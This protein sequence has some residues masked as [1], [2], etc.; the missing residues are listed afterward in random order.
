M[1]LFTSELY[2]RGQSQDDA[3]RDEVDRL[4]ED[5]N[6]QYEQ[7]L[8]QIRPQLPTHIQS[9]LDELLLHDADVW[10]LARHGDQ[11]IMVLRKD[12]PPRDVVILTYT[13]V[14]EP[15]INTAAIPPEHCSRVMQFLYDEFDLVEDDGKK[16]YVQSILFSNGWEVQIKFRDVKVERADAIFPVAG[17]SL[18][19]VSNVFPQ[20][21]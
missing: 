12:I 17:T 16:L 7:R 4:W 9:F 10:S 20:S 18:V 8:Q 2:V 5:A 19:P 11:L 13:L 3:N 14:A 15:A 21:A 6:R 1:K